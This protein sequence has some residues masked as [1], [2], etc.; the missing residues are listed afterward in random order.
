MLL[1]G[2]HSPIPATKRILDIIVTIPSIIL[3]SPLLLVIAIL[4]RINFGSPIIFRQKRPGFH[5]KPFWVHKF[6]S[7]T[8]ERDDQDQL[9]PDGQ[10]MT[11]LGRFL[12]S[13]SLDEL[14]EMINV[15]RG[16]MSWVGPRPLLMQYLER[17]SPEQNR[18]HDV[19]P[20][21]TGWAQI[22]GRNAL[23]W[24]EKFELDVWYVDHWSLWLDIKILLL[25][26]VKVLQR[27]GINQPGQAT[28]DEFMGNH[29]S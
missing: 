15:L 10:R 18:R 19:L 9:L 4:V 29:E 5:G 3:L 26:V 20:G 22:N 28:A 1:V 25:S 2:T 6:R 21:I 23:T 16:E 13:T 11:R 17:Y 12:R 27:Q 24:E 8:N 7:M 14:P